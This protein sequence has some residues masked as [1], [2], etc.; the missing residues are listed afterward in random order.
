MINKL[1]ALNLYINFGRGW[2]QW[3]TPVILELWEA[4]ASRSLEAR[5]SRPASQTRWNPISTK[6]TKIS[7]GWWCVPVIP[8]TREAEAWESLEPG[9][10]RLQWATVAPL[11]SS[12][13]DRVRLCLKKE[14][15][16]EGIDILTV[17]TLV[18]H[19]H[20]HIC[21]YLGLPEFFSIMFYSFRWTGL[22]HLP[23]KLII[24]MVITALFWYY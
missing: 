14:K 9:R 3:L 4:K 17:W 13:A 11:H 20:R 8:A 18:V 2:V 23:L 12:L 1:I 10:Q 16:K 21:I 24:N 22:A 19:E 15:K 5:S 6:N 7:Q